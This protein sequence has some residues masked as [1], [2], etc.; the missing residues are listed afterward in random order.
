MTNP[1]RAKAKSVRPMPPE[2]RRFTYADLLSWPAEERWELI[3]GVAYD[4]SPA[5]SREHEEITVALI[6]Q[7]G[8][9]LK[10]N[11]CRVYTAPFDV[12][13]PNASED[14]MTASTV[15]QPD[16]TVVCDLKKLDAR[17]CLGAP[18]MVVEIVS[19]DSAARDLQVKFQ[20]YE[21]AG[22]PEYR[23]ILPG[24]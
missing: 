21:Q 8:N 4:I 14:A 22:V 19:P 20:L 23:V 18:S 12:R 10:G 7:F 9:F 24:E 17:G 1:M 11:P 2:P 6:L 5:P 15:V 13:L 3:D 16:L